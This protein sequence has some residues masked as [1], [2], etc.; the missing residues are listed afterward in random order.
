[1]LKARFTLLALLAAT[2]FSPMAA[3]AESGV[4]VGVLTC[5]LHASIGFIIG[6]HQKLTC[7]FDPQTPGQPAGEYVGAINTIGLDVGIT[8]GG[9]MAWAVWAPTQGSFAGALAGIYVGASGEI[10]IGVGLGANVLVGGSGRTI[11][12][13][14]VSV[15]GE[16]GVNLALGMSGLELRAVY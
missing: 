1:M 14:P 3:Q 5:R 11:A 6:G 8:A 10:G 4:K 13:Q 15:E 2:L 12:L 16:V 9:A 7:H